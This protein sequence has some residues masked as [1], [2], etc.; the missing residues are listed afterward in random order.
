MV[1]G[2]RDSSGHFCKS[3]NPTHGV[4]AR[5]LHLRIPSS[6]KL[7]FQNTNF[8][9]N[10][11]IHSTAANFCMLILYPVPFLYS[12]INSKNLSINSLEIFYVHDLIV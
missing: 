10:T 6:L 2:V 7:G 4:R 11:N 8:G 9:G 3:T 1:E 12:L 5:R